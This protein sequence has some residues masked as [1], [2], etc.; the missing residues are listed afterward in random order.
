MRWLLFGLAL[1]VAAGPASAATITANSGGGPFDNPATNPAGP[2]DSGEL[3]SE[4]I[5]PTDAFGG[6]TARA[7]IDISGNAAVK[8]QGIYVVTG[9]PHLAGT[10]FP[11]VTDAVTTW[12]STVTNASVQPQ[13]F[14]YSFLLHPFQLVLGDITGISDQDP[15]Y[16]LSSFAVEVRANGVLVF[17]AHATL[18]GGTAHHVLTETGTDLGGVFGGTEGLVIYDFSQYAAQVGIGS[19][20]PGE[21]I[22]VEAK[23]IAHTE[24]RWDNTGGLVTM[25]DPL[26]LKGDPGVSAVIISQDD[27]VGV[28]PVSW[29]AAKRFYR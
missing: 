25:G 22:T 15:N 16:A 28:A 23:L 14:L 29:T 6:M 26:D 7:A 13:S 24:S 9:K 20:G 21:S 17:E 4:T 5:I 12:T 10:T 19:A 18:K 2:V 3:L 1:V 8:L 27:N 11:Q